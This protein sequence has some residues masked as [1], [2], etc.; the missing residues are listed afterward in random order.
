MVNRRKPAVK[1]IDV[2]KLYTSIP[3]GTILS[4]GLEPCLFF[5][6]LNTTFIL[7]IIFAI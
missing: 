6:I 7:D 3:S 4:N 1:I 2:Y 5:D